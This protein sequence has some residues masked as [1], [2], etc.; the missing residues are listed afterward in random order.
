MHPPTHNFLFDRQNGFCKVRSTGSFLPLSTYSW[1]SF[2]DGF[3]ETFFV[4]ALDTLKALGS[5]AEIL[6]LQTNS[7]KDFNLYFCTFVL[8][9][10]FN[11][12]LPS[13]DAMIDL[14]FHHLLQF[15]QF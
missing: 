1:A 5:L 13:P 14:T 4:A 9:I 12:F 15:L 8:A 7:S 3:G 2:L 10:H 11:F 6:G